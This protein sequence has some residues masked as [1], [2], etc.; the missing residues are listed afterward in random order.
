MRRE[1][2]RERERERKKERENEENVERKN[3]K[4][5]NMTEVSERREENER[6]VLYRHH[7]ENVCYNCHVCLGESVGAGVRNLAREKV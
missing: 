4:R 3:G 6:F 1:R 2:E 7:G 5:Q